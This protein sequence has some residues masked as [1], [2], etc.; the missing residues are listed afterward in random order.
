MYLF[1]Y[2]ETS[3]KTGSNVNE[4][5]HHIADIL[6]TDDEIH[7]LRVCTRDKK[8]RSLF[9]YSL[10]KHKNKDRIE[11]GNNRFY[12]G[13]RTMIC[14]SKS[15]LSKNEIKNYGTIT[16]VLQQASYSKVNELIKS[17]NDE[18]NYKQ[19]LSITVP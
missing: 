1:S 9:V 4:L 3:A 7:S 8:K 13:I 19:H 11:D 18:S 6:P 16:L 14:P 2:F 17:Y 12:G 5:F 10:F 15:V